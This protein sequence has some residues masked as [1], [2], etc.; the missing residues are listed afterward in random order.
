VL[1]HISRTAS[2]SPSDATDRILEDLACPACG[3]QDLANAHHRLASNQLRIFCEGCGA[4]ITISM[5]DEQ[6]TT[7]QGW[8]PRPNGRVRLGS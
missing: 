5:S 2:F 8:S 1:P 6:A 7:I 3:H 4:F